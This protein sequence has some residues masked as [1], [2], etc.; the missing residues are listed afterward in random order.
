MASRRA[1]KGLGQQSGISIAQV[2]V[3]RDSVGMTDG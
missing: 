1:G 3:S 2:V